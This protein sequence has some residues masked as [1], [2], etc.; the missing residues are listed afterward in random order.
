[1]S[2][3]RNAIRRVNEARSF[4][5]NTCAASR[6]VAMI[7]EALALSRSYSLIAT[8]PESVGLDLLAVVEALY[9]ARTER[10]AMREALVPFADVSLEGDEEFVDETL[11]QIKYGRTT[12]YS[13]KLGDLRRAAAEAETGA[14]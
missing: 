12:D 5:D 10:D 8:D 1:M 2:D 6:H 4:P 11:L 13:L 7:G 3:V 9:K 14:R